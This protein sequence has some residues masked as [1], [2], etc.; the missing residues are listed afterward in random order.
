MAK[1][2]EKKRLSVLTYRVEKYATLRE[3]GGKEGE[4]QMTSRGGRG[5]DGGG[6]DR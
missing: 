6:G 1:R 5:I 3:E 4:E 2:G